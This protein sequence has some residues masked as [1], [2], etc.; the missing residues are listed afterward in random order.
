MMRRLAMVWAVL[1]ALTLASVA[2]AEGMRS[3]ELVVV[4]VFGVAVIKGQIVAVQF[5]ETRRAPGWN[6]LY[7]TWIVALGLVMMVANAMMSRA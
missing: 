5:M 4:I 1:V 3:R 2:L 6:T 7:R